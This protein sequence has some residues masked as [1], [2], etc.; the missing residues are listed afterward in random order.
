MGDWFFRMS[1]KSIRQPI[2]IIPAIVLYDSG[3]KVRFRL[4]LAGIISSFIII[5]CCPVLILVQIN[6]VGRASSTAELNQLAYATVTKAIVPTR[7]FTPILST[8]TPR[9][10]RTSTS[11]NK[12]LAKIS[13]ANNL[14]KVNLRRSPGY[15][16]K[17]DSADSI[18]EI[19]CGE[20]VELLG[21]TK[22]VDGLK[23]WKVRWNGYTGWIADH[24]ASGKTILIFNP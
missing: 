4:F 18:Y 19:P 2:T 23:W 11:Q 3:L 5:V 14:Y 8:S 21:D 7:T 10:I 13:C 15:V 12:P 6:S 24:T 20:Y 16:N 22:N 1:L 9:V 17:N